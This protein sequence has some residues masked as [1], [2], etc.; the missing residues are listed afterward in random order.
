[1]K[2]IRM[3][4]KKKGYMNPFTICMIVLGML[5]LGSAMHVVADEPPVA[6]ADPDHQTV[7]AGEEACFS[8]SASYDRDGYIV[9]YYWVFGDGLCY[10]GENMTYIFNCV[11]N[12]T[13]SLTVVDDFGNQDT[14]YITVNV[15]EDEPPS[16][17]LMVW[18]E[19]LAT[20]KDEYGVNETIY[21]QAT[22]QRG[23][24]WLTYVWEGTLVL[25][26]L[27]QSYIIIY[28]DE[29]SVYL[30]HGGASETHE[31]E[32]I[33]SESGDYFVKASL[34]DLHDELLDTKEVVITVGDDGSG[35][36]GI[37]PPPNDEKL[38]WIE[39]LTTDKGEYDVHEAVKTEVI[40]KR[41]NDHMDYVWKGILILEVYDTSMVLIYYDEQEVTIPCDGWTQ[42]FSYEFTVATPGE[43]LVRATLYDVHD[44]LMDI[45]EIRI[46][47]EDGA[48]SPNDEK[49][50]WIESLTTDKGE[51][52]VNETVKTQVVVKRGDDLL[53]YVWEGTLVLEVLDNC[54]VIL[55][56]EER[57][58][59]LPYGGAEEIH[60]F[61]FIL[62]ESGNYIVRATL[63]DFSG[64]VA[65]LMRVKLVIGD[66]N[67]GGNGTHPPDDEDKTAPPGD[68][69]GILPLN[70]PDLFTGDRAGTLKGESEKQAALIITV[71]IVLLALSAFA[72]LRHFNRLSRIKK[73]S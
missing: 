18:I 62:A 64:E 56:T 69:Y 21:T 57:S 11:G 73:R 67:S 66:D 15:V 48:T 7:I 42:T 12:F 25:E 63:Y 10:E 14:D 44:E 37:H 19:T 26:V 59:Y 9:A 70:D 45:K 8:G 39:S 36:N 49:P 55:F 58:V 38:V 46:I 28:N 31:F 52:D 4:E 24:D 27:D 6:D 17:P 71:L 61:E 32:F 41:G 68:E 60:D 1:M 54:G 53:T 29:R 3:M 33:L 72:T 23:N 40:V 13:V 5:V 34:Y 43:H 47:V 16:E 35:G 30:P 20:D 22:V 65:D 50:V 51:Y 2:V